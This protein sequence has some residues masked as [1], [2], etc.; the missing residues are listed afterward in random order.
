MWPSDAEELVEHQRH[1]AELSPDPWQPRTGHLRSGGCWVC[2]PRGSSGPGAAGDLAWCAAA[3]LY[4]G[5]TLALRVIP[6]AARAGYVPGLLAMRLGPL[7]D[8][9][10]RLLPQLPDVLLVDG[11]GRDHPRRAGLT[12]HLG[13]EL[14]IPTVGITHR[15]LLATGTWPSEDPGATAPLRLDGDVV[16][17][18]VRTRPGTRPLVVHPGW[19]TDLDTAVEV[20]RRVTARRTPEPLRVARRAAREARTAEA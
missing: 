9:V 7:L 1:L 5:H 13:A 19:R 8:N 2:F 15:P 20:I 10:V 12:L 16:A 11:T 4:D 17:A 6:G 14:D 3:L 18:W